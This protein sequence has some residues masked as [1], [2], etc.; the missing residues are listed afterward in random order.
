MVLAARCV[1]VVLI[2]VALKRWDPDAM[3]VRVATCWCRGANADADARSKTD[4]S[5]FIMLPL[6]C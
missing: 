3:V 5:D 4:T 2:V 1:V 6:I